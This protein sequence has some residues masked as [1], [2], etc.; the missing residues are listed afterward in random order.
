MSW[1][2]LFVI[3]VCHARLCTWIVPRH[4][5]GNTMQSNDGDDESRTISRV[6]SRATNVS[7]FSTDRPIRS[8]EGPV[9]PTTR[10]LLPTR[11]S[12][13]EGSLVSNKVQKLSD[14]QIHYHSRAAS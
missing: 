12:S 11:G 9:G 8:P 1:Q 14:L 4:A 5:G 13:G 10:P 6:E 7:L 2:G 3:A